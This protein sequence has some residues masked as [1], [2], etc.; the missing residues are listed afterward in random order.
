MR[1]KTYSTYSYTITDQETEKIVD[2]LTQRS[3]Q[4]IFIN[5]YE[6]AKTERMM[7]EIVTKKKTVMTRDMFNDLCKS[8]E[9]YIDVQ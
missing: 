2:T 5:I 6:S 9:K 7:Y 3:G 4:T 1:T 8:L